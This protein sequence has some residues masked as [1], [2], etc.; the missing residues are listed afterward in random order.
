MT[1]LYTIVFG[2]GEQ[3]ERIGAITRVAQARVRGWRGRS[4]YSVA[5]PALMLWVHSTLVDTGLA[6]YETYVRRV[7][8]V[9]ARRPAGAP[10]PELRQRAG[11]RAQTAC[12]DA[13]RG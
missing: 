12:G 5:D 6:M 7:D 8:P 13:G 4:T 1:A 2:S 3:A 10:D 11:T 9:D